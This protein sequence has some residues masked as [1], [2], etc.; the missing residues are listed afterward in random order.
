MKHYSIN[1]DMPPAEKY[2]HEVTKGIRGPC[3]EWEIKACRR[4]LRDLERQ[5]TEEFPYIF[6]KSRAQRIYDWFEKCCKHPRG[7]LSGQPIMLNSSQ[8]FDLG[9]VFG[10]VHKDT[11]QRRFKK[12]FDMEGRGNAK[13]VKMS[14][15][16]LYGM[17][18]DCVYPP[19]HIELRQYE[20]SPE[21]DCAAVD[22]E[23]AKIVWNDAVTMGNLSPD[24]QKRLKFLNGHVEHKVRGGQL[25]P[26]SKDTKNKNGA[27]P[28]IYIIDEYH[29]HPTSFI[30]DV[31]QSAMGK[32]AQCL[33]YII[34]TAGNNAENSPCKKEYDICCKI[35]NGE[36]IQEDYFCII[37]QLDKG[38]NPHDFSLL[39]KA[40]PILQEP[41]EYSKIL[42]QEIKS[43]HD[44]AYGSGDPAKI[45]EYLIKRCDLWQEGST[46]KYMEGCMDKWKSLEVSEEEFK[47]LTNGL[48][49]LAGGDLSKRIDLT[50]QAFLFKLND[51]RYA[52]K[53]HGFIPESGIVRH[54]HSDRVPYADWIEKRYC[55]KVDGEVIDYDDLIEYAQQEETE[56]GIKI[57]EWDIDQA[58]ATQLGNEL[59]KYKYDVFEVA[60]KI[61]KLSEPTKLFRE[62]VLQGKLIHEKNQLLDWCVHN[63]YQYSDTNE[64]IRLSKKNKDDSQR[65]D[66]LAAA[67]NCMARITELDGPNV[68]VSQYATDDF[69]NKYWNLGE[70]K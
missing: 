2:A 66:L 4:H 31:G 39:P 23:Q 35:L 3:C 60:Q 43:E 18:S 57:L 46:D 16:A 30:Y 64:N 61:T 48:K 34:T 42:L 44:L 27:A 5:G 67:I 41:T 58:L 26:L 1:N 14:G 40:N 24:I 13:S 36:I 17:C 20:L 32:R 69:L 54:E 56:R 9:C 59:Q 55:S 33:M 63:A 19:G 70:N 53:T 22:R 38:D 25:R 37:R 15:T 8:K 12:A 6:D 50:G 52:L 62:L 45:R 21:V 29:E 51:G 49:C 65:I 28:C 47:K 7:V 11:G 10:W 68:D